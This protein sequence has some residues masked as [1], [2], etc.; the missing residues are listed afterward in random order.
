MGAC[1]KDTVADVGHSG[2]DVCVR[3]LKLLDPLWMHPP[4]PHG[5]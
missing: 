3:V 1:R 5:M 4:W 2:F